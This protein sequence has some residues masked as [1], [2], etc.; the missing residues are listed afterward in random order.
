MPQNGN[1]AYEVYDLLMWRNELTWMQKKTVLDLISKI[2]KD[3]G[4]TPENDLVE[5]RGC[6][7]SYSGTGHN[8]PPAEK[9]AY[10]PDGKWRR[11]VIEN[12]WGWFR[13][14]EFAGLKYA[15]GGTT[16]IDFYTKTKGENVERMIRKQGWSPSECVYVGDA[17]FE[18]GNDATVVGVIET[19]RTTGPEQTAAI[20]KAF[21]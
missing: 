18:G 15:I 1:E 14:L 16:C 9:R 11:N 7:I 19:I 2:L 3:E 17:L 12:N 6:Q 10:D 4:T 21:L 5:D 13:E 20:I 8:A